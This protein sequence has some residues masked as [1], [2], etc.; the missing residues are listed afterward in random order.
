[1]RFIP[2][3]DLPT[4]GKIVGLDGVATPT[5]PAAAPSGCRPRPASRR[6]PAQ[7]HRGHRAPVRRRHREGRRADQDTRPGQEAPGHRRH[8]GPHRP[9]E[10]LRR[11][12]RSRTASTPRRCSSSSTGSA[13]GGLLRINAVALVDGQPDPRP[14]GAARRSSSTTA[15]TRPPPIRPPP[16]QAAARLHLVEGLLIAILD[17]DEVIQLIRTSDNTAMAKERLIAGV[18][19]QRHPGRLHPRDAAAPA[20]QVLP[21]SSWRRSSP[22]CEAHHR[23]QAESRF[24]FFH[25]RRLRIRWL[26]WV[27]MRARKPC[28]RLGRDVGL[29]GPFNS[30]V[31]LLDKKTAAPGPREAS[32]EQGSR[33]QFSTAFLWTPQQHKGRA[34]ADFFRRLRAP[35]GTA[36][37]NEVRQR[38]G[39]SSIATASTSTSS[40]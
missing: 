6:P 32:I 34:Q 15:S 30:S 5:R 8:Q 36:T 22:S 35:A 40:R 39:G 1:M 16:R 9:R 29:E 13:A 33:T 27:D 24:C 4:G 28:F 25:R 38:H 20:H 23:G 21:G 7:G 12:S 19:P 3:P 18:R 37:L 31:G 17:I 2:G 10:G 11:S 26:A 14:Q